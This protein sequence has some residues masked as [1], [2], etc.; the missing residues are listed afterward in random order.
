M[1]RRMLEALTY[2]RLCVLKK[3]VARECPHDSVFESSDERCQNCHLGRECHWLGCLNNFADFAAKPT[4]TIHASLL[5]GLSLIEANNERM[6][7]DTAECTCE[8]CTWARGA[9]QLTQAFQSLSLG[10]LFRSVY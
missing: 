7:H 6:Q 9:Q 8:S 1:R 2:P 3:I 5:Y 4:Y 10:N